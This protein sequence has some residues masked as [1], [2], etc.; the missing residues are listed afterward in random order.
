M[1]VYER[2]LKSEIRQTENG[3]DTSIAYSQIEKFVPEWLQ[4]EVAKANV[5]F[6]IDRLVFDENFFVLVKSILQLISD[7]HMMA[8]HKYN[9]EYAHN[10]D[11]LKK[12]SLQVGHRTLF[13][14]LSHYNSKKQLLGISDALQS[15]LLYTE[16]YVTYVSSARPT[17]ILVDFINEY[18]LKDSLAN[19]WEL[20]FVCQDEPTRM[21]IAK[22]TA[23]LIN[24][25]FIIWG[26]CAEQHGKENE[27]LVQLWST[28][29][30]L[31]KNLVYKLMDSQCHKN[32][33]R[34]QNYFS[35]LLQIATGGRYQTEYMLS[36]FNLVVD[37]CDLMLGDKSPKAK[38]ETEKR[39]SM[40]GSVS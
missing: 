11:T 23:R 5:D 37:I 24:R 31:M 1:L 29:D 36:N 26:R 40:G 20:M 22:F 13:D 4:K 10:F 17:T 9:F 34:L 7:K 6:V 16:S 35:L 32:W 39:V 21:Q 12:L 27:R 25:A 19:F 8:Q 28:L 15:I 3:V 30:S 2:K 33:S 38:L 14:F 18:Y